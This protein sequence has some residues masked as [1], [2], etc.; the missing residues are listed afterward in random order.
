MVGVAR[1]FPSDAPGSVGC[2]DGTLLRVLPEAV[3][4]VETE[5]PV[6]EAQ[7]ADAGVRAA[8]ARPRVDDGVAHAAVLQPAGLTAVQK[9]DLPRRVQLAHLGYR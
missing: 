1:R 7:V 2:P 8:T 3:D 9:L 5:L 4:A 6:G